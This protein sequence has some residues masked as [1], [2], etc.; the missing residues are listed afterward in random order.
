VATEALCILSGTQILQGRL[1]DAAA[2]CQEALRLAEECFQQSRRTLPVR[3]LAYAR[4]GLV[5]L[6]WDEVEVA[7]EY[8]REGVRIANRWG[9]AD[10]LLVSYREM[11]HALQA[12]GDPEGALD[13]VQQGMRVAQGM[14]SWIRA[15]MEAEQANLWLVQGNL[16]GA[17]RW[18]TENGLT[19]LDQIPF[20]REKEY[21]VL[22]RVLIAQGEA[23]RALELLAHLVDLLETL[24]AEHSLISALALQALAF[25]AQD[26]EE[27]ALISLGRALVL[28]EA[29]GYV[30][31]F[32]DEG[33]PMAR[34]LQRALAQGIA[35]E[36]CRR[37]LPALGEMAGAP[38]P[39][40]QSLVEPLTERELEVLG[41]IAAGLS[42][43]E[44]ADELVVAVSTVKTHINHLYGKLGV[45]SRVQAVAEAR[46]VGLL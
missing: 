16:A 18:A 4:L 7:V 21:R 6:E 24:K 42:N 29:E 23:A 11:A 25:Q 39:G 19:A 3:S 45:R 17:M 31:A 43:Q 10:T 5:H 8:A 33:Q 30:R 20:H 32:V 37:L 27:S 28:A 34:L 35:T 41:L 38:A 22:A 2:S 13:A 14:S 9:T 12:G 46:E 1:R 26:D 36:Y 44:I 40:Q 15:D